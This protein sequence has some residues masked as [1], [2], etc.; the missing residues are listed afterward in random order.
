MEFFSGQ[1]EVMQ[2]KVSKKSDGENVVSNAL[3]LFGLSSDRSVKPSKKVIQEQ[4]DR[5]RIYR[6]EAI[7]TLLPIEQ[8]SMTRALDLQIVALENGLAGFKRVPLE[9]LREVLKWRNKDGWPTF[10]LFSPERVNVFF[11]SSWSEGEVLIPFVPTPLAGCYS[12]IFRKLQD[13]R[14]NR[15]V[16]VWASVDFSGII[17][18]EVR[19]IIKRSE[20][21][22]T[23][24]HIVAEVAQWK[25]EET[26]LPRLNTDPLVIGYDGNEFWLLATFDLTPLEEAV[27]QICTGEIPGA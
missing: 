4:L 5:A 17:P 10:A 25:L 3:T 1:E 23:S 26:E 9:K 13:R 16:V 11:K 18:A 22:F 19:A 2:T 15:N 8:V 27:R 21:L 7:K 24:I 12:D 20:R 6:R 14:G